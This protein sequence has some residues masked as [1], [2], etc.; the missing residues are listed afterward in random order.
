MRLLVVNIALRRQLWQLD[1]FTE[2]S[3][4]DALIGVPQGWTPDQ[5]KQFQDYPSLTLPRKRG[6]VRVGSPAISPSA[7]APSSCP[8]TAGRRAHLLRQQ[9]PNRMKPPLPRIES[10]VPRALH[11][12]LEIAKAIRTL[13]GPDEDELLRQRRAEIAAIRR[14]LEVLPRDLCQV[15]EEFLALAKAELRKAIK[16]RRSSPTM[17]PATGHAP[18]GANTEE[19]ERADTRRTLGIAMGALVKDYDPEEPRRPK[20]SAG[21]GEWTKEGG[22]GS[23]G[24]FFSRH[25]QDLRRRLANLVPPQLRTY[26]VIGAGEI[27]VD[28]PKHPVQFTDSSGRP[29]LDDQGKPMLRPDDLPPEKYAQ[30]GAA[31]HLA[32]Y[33]RS[34]KDAVQNELDAPNEFNEQALAG[35][36]AKISQELAPFVHGGSLDAER[37]DYSYVRDYRHYTSIATGV[38]MAA[39]GV[40]RDDYLAIADA[41]ASALSTFSAD[42]PR[43]EV[44]PHLSKR[45]VEDNL[46]GYDLYESGR[47]R[48]S[49]E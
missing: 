16:G 15:G 44:Y 5:I 34:F 9:R 7:A 24:D 28:H 23:A 14:D 10:A 36:T 13:A 31:S 1:Y 38:F 19:G 32:D 29:I 20:Y 47:I 21:G 4:P 18:I 25:L 40:S 11:V 48:Q 30:A 39:A 26:H 27:P 3:I 22:S 2:G 43:D 37:F 49:R 17:A 45:D 8:A 41:Y 46:K 35:L 6:R 42:E 12:Q 33:V